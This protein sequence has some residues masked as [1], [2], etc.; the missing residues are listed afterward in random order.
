[1]PSG[2]FLFCPVL[3]HCR[4]KKMGQ[5]KKTEI[6]KCLLFVYAISKAC[7]KASVTQKPELILN[8]P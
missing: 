8:K 3:L 7:Q 5:L 4:Y 1:M 2:M 6:D